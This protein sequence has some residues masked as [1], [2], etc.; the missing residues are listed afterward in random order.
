M[1]SLSIAGKSVRVGDEFLKL[2][3][4]QQNN[5]VAEIASSLLQSA[6]TRKDTTK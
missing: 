2:S 1:P 6:S 3:P 4:E 5:V